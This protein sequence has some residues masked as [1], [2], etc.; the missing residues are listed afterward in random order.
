MTFGVAR[1]LSLQLALYLSFACQPASLPIPAFFF[2]AT[3]CHWSTHSLNSDDCACCCCCVHCN[4]VRVLS[5]KVHASMFW[6]KPLPLRSFST[7]VNLH[8]P[9][10]KVG[11]G[12][13]LFFTIVLPALLW[14]TNISSWSPHLNLNCLRALIS[15]QC[16]QCLT[17][18]PKRFNQCA[19][20]WHKESEIRLVFFLAFNLTSV[21][22]T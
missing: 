6:I 19:D 5:F 17:K 2:A 22:V 7:T 21:L 4:G 1:L 13:P 11:T 15:V 10:Q 3:V 18:K 9:M 20:W 16:S 14:S 12:V 8:L